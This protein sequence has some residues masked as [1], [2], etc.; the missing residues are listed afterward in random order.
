MDFR[1]NLLIALTFSAAAAIT[2]IVGSTEHAAS[3]E[4]EVIFVESGATPLAGHASGETEPLQPAFNESPC[5]MASV[6]PEI[7]P[8]LRCGMVSVPRNY[9][10]PGSGQFKLAV[11]VVKSPQQPALPDRHLCT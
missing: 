10:A 1:G 3:P 8:R 7:R 5:E 6:S 2:L 9:D 11:V 4:R